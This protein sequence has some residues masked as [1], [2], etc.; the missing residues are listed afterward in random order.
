MQ[1]TWNARLAA[2]GDDE[3]GPLDG[4]GHADSILIRAYIVGLETQA[5]AAAETRARTDAEAKG[6][7]ISGSHG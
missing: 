4:G 5:R 2:V 1:L 3:S 6:Y 7:Y